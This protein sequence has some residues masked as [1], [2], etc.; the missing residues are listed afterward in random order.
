MAV[1][2]VDTEDSEA[3]VILEDGQT[4]KP[5]PIEVVHPEHVDPAHIVLL[6]EPAWKLR[7]TIE[8]DRSYIRVKVAR[9]APLTEPDRYICFLDI[10]DDAIYIVKELD[11]LTEA[12]RGIVLEELERRYLTSYIERINHLKNEYGVS[13]WDVD[14]DRGHREFVAKNIAENAQWLG[15]GRLF[16]L[17]VDGNRFEIRNIQSL[18][19]RSRGFVDLVL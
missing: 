12:N 13:Y 9:A 5:T 18:D 4:W 3:L 14:T 16:L 17:D 2:D 6:R 19:K 8:G 15:E 10:K 1:M 11:E 7:M